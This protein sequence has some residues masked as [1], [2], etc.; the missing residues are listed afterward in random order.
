MA[1]RC[2][3]A[4]QSLYRHRS[5]FTPSEGVGETCGL[6]TPSE[7]VRGAER[8]KAASQSLYRH[9]GDFTPSKGVGETCGSA[10][11]SEGVR[12]AGRCKAASQSLYRHRGDFTPSEGVGET[13]GLA[14]PSEGVKKGRKKQSRI[15]ASIQAPQRFHSFQRSQGNVRIGY[16]FGRSDGEIACL[17]KVRR[18]TNVNFC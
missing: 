11:P 16:S 6:A 10:T 7:G 2:K 12:G 9:R 18:L 15:T 17:R 13:C 4:S 14:T 1:K 8:S 5:D 3:A